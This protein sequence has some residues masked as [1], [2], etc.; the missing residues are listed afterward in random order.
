[1]KEKKLINIF[2]QGPVA[3]SFI[4][5]S[6]AKHSHKKEIGA[7]SIFLG[8][9]RDDLIDGKKVAAIEYS[10]YTEMA[11]MQMAIIRDEIF[12]LYGLTCL[13]IH[14]SLG[15]VQAGEISLFVFASS[16]HRRAAIDACNEVVERIK[17]DLPVWGKEVFD[18]VSY[19]WKQ[20]TSG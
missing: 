17:K 1:M 13:H 7:H 6:I 9:V 16:P 12:S 15:L 20:N 11:L 18:D 8:Q 14:H 10:A 5:E 3:P 2:V 19:T 4:A